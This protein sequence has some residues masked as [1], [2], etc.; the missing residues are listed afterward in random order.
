MQ[1]QTANL[2][3]DALAFTDIVQ[4]NFSEEGGQLVGIEQEAL[5]KDNELSVNGSSLVQPLSCTA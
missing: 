4:C 3:R 5:K 1:P 2:E